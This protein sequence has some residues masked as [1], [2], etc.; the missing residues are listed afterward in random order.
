[1]NNRLGQ[2]TISGILFFFMAIIIVSLT[3]PLVSDS[4][5]MGLDVLDADNGTITN[6]GFIKVMILYW[7]VFFV[8]MLLVILVIIIRT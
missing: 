4:I 1:M 5:D 3:M 8:S 6:S 7:P 2:N